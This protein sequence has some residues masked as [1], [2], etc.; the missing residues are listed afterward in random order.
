MMYHKAV[1][2]LDRE[3]ALKILEVSNPK[4]QK[5][6]GRIVKN[7]HES[8]WNY[9]RSAI[10]YWGNKKKFTQNPSL[11][12]ELM[13]TVGTTLVEA[14]PYDKIWGVGLSSKDV[15]IKNRNNWQGQNL[16]GEILTA[17]R[18]RLNGGVY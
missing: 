10:V 2:F 5:K 17:L 3:V 18:T 15:R 8:T 13:S 11:H 16:L 7:F 6:L 14:S 1:L 9:Y 12:A 4:E